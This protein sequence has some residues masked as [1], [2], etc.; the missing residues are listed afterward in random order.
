LHYISSL[1]SGCTPARRRVLDR[2]AIEV[3]RRFAFGFRGSPMLPKHA[4]CIVAENTVTIQ[5][6]KT[7]DSWLL[8]AGKERLLDIKDIQ[9][10][11][12]CH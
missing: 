8:H 9:P 12:G 3:S 10:G 4:I 5:F 2:F 6:L 11:G 7:S 1:F